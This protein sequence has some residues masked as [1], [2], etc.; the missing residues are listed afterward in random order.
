MYD[1]KDEP[2]EIQPNIEIEQVSKMEK[3]GNPIV[4]LNSEPYTYFERIILKTQNEREEEEKEKRR[5]GL[6]I[7]RQVVEEEKKK[8]KGISFLEKEEKPRT[9]K[10]H[11]KEIGNISILRNILNVINE[12]KQQ[13]SSIIN[14]DITP[15][16]VKEWIRQFMEIKT[17]CCYREDMKI[18]LNNKSKLEIVN[19]IYS[20]ITSIILILFL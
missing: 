13:T 14:K 10:L 17:P 19:E 6:V 5:A 9:P 1:I 3:L 2:E 4:V 11:L 7:R 8:S 15:I 20:N 16:I 12:N 18:L